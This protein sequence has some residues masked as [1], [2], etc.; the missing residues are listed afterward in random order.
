LCCCRTGGGRTNGVYSGT[1]VA[2]IKYPGA[3]MK[4]EVSP[5][6]CCLTATQ[7]CHVS[8]ELSAIMKMVKIYYRVRRDVATDAETYG[9]KTKAHTARSVQ[10]KM[11]ATIC[12]GKGEKER[13]SIVFERRNHMVNGF[14]HGRLVCYA[15]TIPVGTEDVKCLGNV[16]FLNKAGDSISM[17]IC[18]YLVGK[19]VTFLAERH[20]VAIV[21]TENV[22]DTTALPPLDSPVSSSEIA[23][24]ISA[25]PIVATESVAALTDPVSHEPLKEDEIAIP[26]AVMPP[27]IDTSSVQDTPVREFPDKRMEETSDAIVDQFHEGAIVDGV[28]DG[29]KA[30]IAIP[31]VTAES[32]A[33][34][35]A[36]SMVPQTGGGH[37]GRTQA[38]GNF[39]HPSFGFSTYH[40]RG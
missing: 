12:W 13:F 15:A 32:D 22:A 3:R 27:M 20:G 16:E 21:A 23:H 30:A 1:T 37:F 19:P 26:T 33:L 25:A 5:K 34:P 10:F 4:G 28:L 39:H 38:G 11:A 9:K 2:G 6:I 31:V 7:A 35:V 29:E 14:C 18:S 17:S 8:Q 36:T 40:Q 24:V